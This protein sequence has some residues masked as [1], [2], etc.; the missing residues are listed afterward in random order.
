[1]PTSPDVRPGPPAI[2]AG[3][4]VLYVVWGSTYLAISIAV[5]TFPP[6]IMAAIRFG[7]AGVI[8]LTWSIV[9]RASVIRGRPVASG[10]TRPS[11][12]PCCSAAGWASSPGAS[13]PSRRASRP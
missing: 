1:M 5:E 9:A 3:M 12:A 10:A 8:L 4:L 13:R 11:S 7:L 6:F 2:W